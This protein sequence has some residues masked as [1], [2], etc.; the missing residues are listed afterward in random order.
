[1][2]KSLVVVESPAKARTIRKYLGNEFDVKASVGHIR[3]LPVQRLGVDIKKG[4]IPEYVDIKGKQKIISELKKAAR[5]KEVI[6]LAPDPDREGEAIAWHIAEALKAKGRNFKRVLFHELTPKAIRYAIDHP[7]ELSI[8]RFESQQ[9]RRILDRLVGYQI[10]PLLWDKVK[11]GLSAGRV[12]SVALRIIVQRERE[13][14]AFTPEEYWSL[15]AKLET[16]GREFSARL[17]REN[18]EKIELKTGERT[19]GII[20]LI[21]NSPFVVDKVVSKERRRNPLPPFTT[22]Q[23]QQEAFSRLRFP[24]RHTMSLAQKL[25]E[26]I[27]L[28]TEGAVGLITYMRTDSVRV[29]GE[30]VN[31]VRGLIQD[32]FGESYLPSKPRSYRNKKGSQDAHEAIRPTS[33]LR[34]PEVVKQHLSSD[35]YAL[36]ELIWKR[37]V[38]SQMKAALIDQTSADIKVG[39]FIFRATGSV[40]KFKG[41]LE[42]IGNASSNE[43]EVLPP[44]KEGM[45]L[46]L[47]ELLPKQHFTQPPPR[48]T[49]ATLVKE[50]EDN[51]IGRPSTYAAIIS[52]LRDKEYIQPVKGQLAPTELGFLVNDLLVDNF[53][54]IMN[55]EFTAGMESELDEVEEGKTNWSEVLKR[56][57]GSFET[58]LHRA[59]KEMLSLKREGLKTEIK[60]DLCGSDMVLKWGRNGPFLSC[61]RYPKC[62]NAKDYIRDENGRI[63]AVKPETAETEEVCE[64]CGKPMV[65]KKG[66]YG[67]F[68]ACSGYPECKNTRPVN[69]DGQEKPPPLPPGVEK[70]CEKCGS[71]LEV[72]RSRMGNLFIACTNYPKCK[73]IIPFPTGIKCPRKGCTGEL[74]ERPSKKGV[75]FG[76]SEFPKCRFTLRNRPVKQTCPQCGS[77]Y[78]VES[79]P[80]GASVGSSD[81]V[82]LKCPNKNCDYKVEPEPEP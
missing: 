1:M 72:K 30:A 60:C 10:S 82:A 57:Y 63:K 42:V 81:R 37:F 54:G 50:L 52:T 17:L 12:Q 14:F 29:A 24:T 27:E 25:Y 49:E 44:L 38:A 55:V 48:F 66:R 21:K 61:S 7:E 78:L 15:T 4:F 3:D 46:D 35:L 77:P 69:G 18:Q 26:G 67:P 64:K 76:C 16:D 20:D 9:A 34:S 51:G 6:Y 62:R 36:Y 28:G 53:P 68:L 39:R 65:V 33:V 79:P 22:S 13:I 56:F 19:Q 73:S 75:F 41:F 45:K 47:K 23:L 43:R 5:G 2:K 40:I 8:E 58:D 70:N 71:P 59:E 74:V 31:E 80:K 11:R 32:R